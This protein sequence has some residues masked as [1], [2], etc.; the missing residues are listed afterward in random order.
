MSLSTIEKVLL[1]KPLDL[2]HAIPDDSLATFAPLLSSTYVEPGET[3]F[4]EGEPGDCLYVVVSGE[5]AAIRGGAVFRT[6]GQ[7]EI[8]GE[9]AALE[10]QPRQ[11]TVKA[12]SETHLLEV[13]A[14][15]MESMIGSQ[16][17][18]GMAIIRVLCR[19]LGQGTA[20]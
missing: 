6:V 16:A 13:T 19:R 3:V 12:T 4:A 15:H 1:L 14:H 10:P 11:E 9:M 7:G 17:D 20:S 5:L 18:I 2:F 8:V